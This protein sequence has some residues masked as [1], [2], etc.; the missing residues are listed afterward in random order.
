[1]RAQCS[2]QA[3]TRPE[4]VVLGVTLLV[5]LAVRLWRLDLTKVQY[6]EADAASL[7]AAWKFDGQL[8]IAGTI[9][10]TG[11]ANAPGWSYVLAPGLWLTDSPYAIVVTGVLCSVL[12]TALCWWMGR[13]W[14]GA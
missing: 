4:A 11:L 13:R 6:D 10:S 5:A 3:V 14:F 8:P 9:G 2:A 1:M 12:T 7:V